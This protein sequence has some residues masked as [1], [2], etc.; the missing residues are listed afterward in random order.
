MTCPHGLQAGAGI[1]AVSYASL[2]GIEF[3]WLGANSQIH[4]RWAF[5]QAALFHNFDVPEI[6][7]SPK[8]QPELFQQPGI[9]RLAWLEPGQVF[10]YF[11]AYLVLIEDNRSHYR[12]LTGVKRQGETG[13]VPDQVKLDFLCAESG[14]EITVFFG[15]I[16]SRPFL[17][18]PN[19]FRMEMSAFAAPTSGT[20]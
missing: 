20:L 6:P 18:L 2:V 19:R 17:F 12:L 1:C 13:N 10:Q 14:A 5:L 15:K 8:V 3:P 4:E 7:G 16:E 11:R 9:V